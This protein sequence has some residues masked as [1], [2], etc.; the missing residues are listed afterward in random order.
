MMGGNHSQGLRATSLRGGNPPELLPPT[1][2]ALGCTSSA[3][4]PGPAG[5]GCRA[6]TGDAGQ[7]KTLREV[8]TKELV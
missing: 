4:L 5:S 7:D 8:R 3:L 2:E 6:G 1:A